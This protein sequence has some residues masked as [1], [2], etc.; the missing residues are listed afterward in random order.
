MNV[1]WL[2][3]FASNPIIQVHTMSVSIHAEIPS[4][5]IE[6]NTMNTRFEY[7]S[8]SQIREL[9]H[10]PEYTYEEF[11]HRYESIYIPHSPSRT[12]V[13]TYDSILLKRQL[14]IRFLIYSGRLNTMM[15]YLEQYRQEFMT[16]NNENM[17]FHF[18][19]YDMPSNF[20]MNGETILHC[21]VRSNNIM[22]SY[23]I[24]RQLIHWSRPNSFDSASYRC[25]EN[26][27]NKLWFNPFTQFCNHDNASLFFSNNPNVFYIKNSNYHSIN[28]VMELI[29]E[30]VSINQS[31]RTPNN[32]LFDFITSPPPQHIDNE[33]A[34]TPRL[35]LLSSF[36]NSLQTPPPPPP[37]LRRQNAITPRYMDY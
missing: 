33:N 2:H 24:G 26:I 11:S 29:R 20:N 3:K 14:W 17:F 12:T 5:F 37:R 35:N 16:A 36:N 30:V 4:F 10:F 18:I 28:V 8:P 34:I 7:K 31:Q 23:N 25:Y 1:K 19:N 15:E 13:N 21:Y 6:N 27:H 32:G 22:E 9:Y